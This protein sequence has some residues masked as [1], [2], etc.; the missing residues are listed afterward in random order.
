MGPMVDDTIKVGNVVCYGITHR[1]TKA[2]ALPPFSPACMQLSDSLSHPQ[3]SVERDSNNCSVNL[4]FFQYAHH[5][6]SQ[7][8]RCLRIDENT[9]GLE[10]AKSENH[11]HDL[12][13]I[14]QA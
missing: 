1:V 10:T 13:S 3:A 2:A 7:R 8:R 12:R 9:L 6:S 11:V 4:I 14:Q 5:R